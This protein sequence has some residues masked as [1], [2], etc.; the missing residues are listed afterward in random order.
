[1]DKDKVYD[2]FFEQ[3]QIKFSKGYEVFEE[4]YN[5]LKDKLKLKRKEVQGIGHIEVI[6][7]KE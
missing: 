7:T 4:V 2:I 5:E 3:K 6:I 1:M